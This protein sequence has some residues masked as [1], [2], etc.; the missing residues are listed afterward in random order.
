M[1]KRIVIFSILALLLLCVS[2]VSAV[3]YAV[4]KIEITPSGDLTT[5][6]L[7]TASC[8]LRLESSGEVTIP[9][10]HSIELYTELD[11]PKWTYSILVGGVG[12]DQTSGKRYLTL[13][14]WELSYPSTSEV[15]V[16]IL[17]EGKAPAVTATM[18][19]IVLR[20]HQLDSNENLV[21][22][23]E[24]EYTR[25]VINPAD[26]EATLVV[27]EEELDD[28]D[29]A[30]TDAL[31]KGIDTSNARAKYDAADT[32]IKNAKIASP[33]QAMTYLTNAQTFLD[34]GETLL[35]QA[36]ATKAINDATTEINAV[37]EMITYFKVNRSMG[38][39]ARVL[40]IETQLAFAK[41]DLEDAQDK[42]ASA[43]YVSAYGFGANALKKATDVYNT[44]AALK[45]ELGEGFVI[46]DVGGYLYYVLIVV[47]II[48]VALIGILFY[49]RFTRWDELG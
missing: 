35:A 42:M 31:A 3:N 1:K 25:T 22:G 26:I 44:S 30:L 27:M 7:V 28:L 4:E 8:I 34:E 39:D 12:E 2:A 23:G 40:S 13:S 14:N 19:K 11:T 36:Q 46:P 43:D 9:D 18:D 16:N 32:A 37:D 47:I 49:R 17:L 33:G 21:T 20:V 45:E 41:S 29:A 24:E 6:E 10:G 15:K 38:S 5:G 48:V